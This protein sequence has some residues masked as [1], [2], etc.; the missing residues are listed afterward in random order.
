MRRPNNCRCCGKLIEGV[1][2]NPYNVT[3]DSYECEENDK[4]LCLTC[5]QNFVKRRRSFKGGVWEL[6]ECKED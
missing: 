6:R 4:K 1:K 5:A 2:Y 3:F